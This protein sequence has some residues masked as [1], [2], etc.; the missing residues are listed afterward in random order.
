MN[1]GETVTGTIEKI[2]NGRA[3]IVIIDGQRYIL[4]IQNG[5]SPK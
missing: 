4:E 5:R 1:K 2:K 3:T